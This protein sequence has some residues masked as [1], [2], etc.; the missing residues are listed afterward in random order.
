MKGGSKSMK[1]WVSEGGVCARSQ[2]RVEE[3]DAHRSLSDASGGISQVG[4]AK[5]PLVEARYISY[6]EHLGDL[7]QHDGTHQKTIGQPLV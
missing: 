7:V 5:Y 4:V 2:L 3:H 6:V 1:C